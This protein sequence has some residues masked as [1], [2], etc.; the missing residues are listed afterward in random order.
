MPWMTIVEAVEPAFCRVAS[1]RPR[2]IA[3]D[4]QDVAD[5]LNYRLNASMRPR[6]IAVDDVSTVSVVSLQSG[7][8]MRPRLIAVDDLLDSRLER[9]DE[10]ASMR[11]RLIAVDDPVPPS[12]PASPLLRFNEATAYC[13]G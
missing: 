7:A 10:R 13:R 8:S 12:R 11:P 3:V 6:L 4:D 9:T 1:M 5:A 2:L